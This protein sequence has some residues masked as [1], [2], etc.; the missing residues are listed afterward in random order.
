MNVNPLTYLMNFLY[1][2]TKLKIPSLY[3]DYAI[4]YRYQSILQKK[5]L[6]MPKTLTTSKIF[7]IAKKNRATFLRS[8]YAP[9]RQAWYQYKSLFHCLSNSEVRHDALVM[10]HSMSVPHLRHET[11][12]RA[13]SPHFGL[14]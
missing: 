5:T 6:P 3:Q 12:K 11:E 14:F 1:K 7:N 10:T 2:S 4:N 8:Y 9:L 13:I